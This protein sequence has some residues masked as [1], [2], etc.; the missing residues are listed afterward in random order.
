MT[1]TQVLLLATFVYFVLLVATIHFTRATTRRA[2]GALAGGGTVAVVRVG[3]ESLCHAL[4][5]W[6]YPPTD[7][8]YGPILIYP[9]VI[10][11]FALVA[12][13]GWR[14]TRR[15]GWRGQMLFLGTVSIL[16]TLRDYLVAAPVLKIIVFA[17]GIM[18]VLVDAA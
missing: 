4:G 6:R 18:T 10:V 8:P 5:F 11:M 1:M 17:P 16:G 9:L 13:V 15:F 2:V 12:L 14:V 7:T 3:V